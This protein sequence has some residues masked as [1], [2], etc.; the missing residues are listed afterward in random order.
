MELTLTE[1][2]SGLTQL[3]KGKGLKE[4]ATVKVALVAEIG[5][6]V[7]MEEIGRVALEEVV[8]ETTVTLAILR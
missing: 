6:A 7:L 4:E 2:I 3:L 5:K 8:R 1:E